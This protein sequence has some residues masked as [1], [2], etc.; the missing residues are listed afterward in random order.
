MVYNFHVLANYSAIANVIAI[1]I[2]TFVLIP[3]AFVF[4][5]LSMFNMDFYILKVMDY[6]VKIIVGMAKYTTNLKYSQT[7][8]GHITGDSLMIYLLGLFWFMIW[9]SKLRYAGLV[10]ILASI[11]LMIYYKK[12][13]LVLDVKKVVI[14]FEN[15]DRELEL[16]SKNKL[17]NFSKNYWS[18]WFGK[19]RAKH[20]LHPY[21]EDMRLMTKNGKIIDIIF[22]NLDCNSSADLVISYLDATCADSSKILQ[23]KDLDSDFAFVWCSTETCYFRLYN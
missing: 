16:Y 9:R 10:V 14:G 3:C 8:T 23:V 6:F 1:P 5:F 2:T 22:S 20:Y 18:L 7:Y 12:P 21:Q 15:K 11:C 4:L 17:S 13:D 19:S